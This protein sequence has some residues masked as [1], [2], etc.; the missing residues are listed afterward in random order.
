[1]QHQ[2]GRFLF[3]TASIPDSCPPKISSSDNIVPIL[4]HFISV[5]RYYQIKPKAMQ[6]LE[7]KAALFS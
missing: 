3:T 2:G 1:M 5:S 6:A 4:S 7:N